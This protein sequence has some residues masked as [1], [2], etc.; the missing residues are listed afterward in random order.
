MLNKQKHVVLIATKNPGRIY[1][2]NRLF[3]LSISYLQI[4]GTFLKLSIEK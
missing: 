2:F 3:V 4:I 1:Y